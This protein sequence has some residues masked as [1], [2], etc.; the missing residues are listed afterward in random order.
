V[1]PVGALLLAPLAG[2]HEQVGALPAPGASDG[3]RLGWHGDLDRA[4]AG[5]ATEL[6]LFAGDRP[7]A[8]L[9][10]WGAALTARAGARRRGRYEDPV[11]GSLSYWTDN[12]SVYYYRTAPGCDYTETLGRKLDELVADGLPVGSLQLYSWF[13]PHEQLRPVSEEGAPVVPPT[14]MLRWEPREDLFPGGLEPLRR[15]RAGLDPK[16]LLYQYVPTTA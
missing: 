3:V 2:F 7:R 6:A 8:L 5:F 10:A 16:S 12:G 14:G 15:A 11:V 13:Y 1:A 4:P 9:D